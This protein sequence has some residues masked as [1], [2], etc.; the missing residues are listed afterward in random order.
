MTTHKTSPLRYKALWLL[1]W[2]L[3]PLR[4]ALGLST[5]TR[6]PLA[7]LLELE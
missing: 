1:V 6:R 5:R 4:F 2:T 7:V 3:K